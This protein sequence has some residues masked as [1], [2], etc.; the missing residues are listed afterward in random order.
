MTK[1]VTNNNRIGLSILSNLKKVAIT[2]NTSFKEDIREYPVTYILFFLNLAMFLVM[3]LVGGT[4]NTYVLI[5]F[6]AK[7]NT[8]IAAGEFWR[9]FTSMFIHIGFTHLLFN[10]YALFILGKFSEKIFG[11]GRFILIYLVSGLTGSLLSYLL[12]PE[13]S[14]GASGAIFGL[15]GAIL[16]FGWKKPAY[17][18]T[19]LISN[20]AIVLVINLVLG[21][22]STG[23]D[24]YAHFG[25]LV[26]GALIGFIFQLRKQ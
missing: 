1:I 26:G 3:T 14:A 18:K 20:F 16:A 21:F 19:G 7:V 8:L 2:M 17:W 9:L 11:H 22:I 25:G 23:I 15:M 10:L 4:T 5:F 24:N 12:G 6:G 13:L